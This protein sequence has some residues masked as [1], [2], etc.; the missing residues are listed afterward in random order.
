MSILIYLDMTIGSSMSDKTSLPRSLF[1]Y[2]Y[3]GVVSAFLNFP[4][5]VSVETI[6]QN[7]TLEKN[8]KA[9]I[10]SLQESLEKASQGQRSEL[11]KQL[12]IVYF[13]D[14]NLEKAFA[15]FLEAL[16]SAQSEAAASVSEEELTLYEKALKIYLDH[17]GPAE[18]REGAQIIL[19]EY[20]STLK[21]HPDYFLLGYLIAVA[22]ANLDRFDTF[23]S[24]F[25]H[26]YRYFPQH[27]MA[28]KTKTVLHT[29]LFARAQTPKEQEVQRLA[30]LE[31]A[32]IALEKNPQDTALYKMMISFSPENNKHE[33][34]ITYLN[35]IIE[36]NIIIPRAD[37]AFFIQQAIAT[38]QIEL[39]QRFVYKAREWYPQSRVID[40]AQA[41]LKERNSLRR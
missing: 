20:S 33:A 25:Y 8:H 2:F 41:V 23:F 37:I 34:V 22:E 16:K 26:S 21:D 38:Q 30:I 24:R 31:N 11:Q 4:V 19:T 6:P 28:Y 1:A 36:G 5:I 29:K 35:K 3:L 13:K 17:H 12:A 9:A 32:S 27:Y 14:Q 39:A 7:A 18:A 10:A 40:A 15:V